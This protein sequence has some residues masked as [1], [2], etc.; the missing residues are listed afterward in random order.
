MFLIQGHDAQDAQETVVST[1]RTEMP[2]TKTPTSAT[3]ATITSATNAIP[4]LN[5]SEGTHR[6]NGFASV[7]VAIFSLVSHIILSK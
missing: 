5:G 2:T 4:T 1:M 3:N 7:V 6:Y